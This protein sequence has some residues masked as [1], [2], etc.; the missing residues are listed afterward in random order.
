M[1][2][3]IGILIACIGIVS[4]T[5]WAEPATVDLYA[6]KA[7]VEAV[8]QLA[9]DDI[10]TGL[11]AKAGVDGILERTE[12]DLGHPVTVAELETVQGPTQTSADLTWLQ[13]AAGFVS[14]TNTMIAIGSVIAVAS[15]IFLFGQIIVEMLK[16][17]VM[18]PAIMYESALVLSGVGLTAYA[19]TLGETNAGT[20][21][22]IGALLYGGGFAWIVSRHDN[23][24]TF[25]ASSVGVILAIA[26]GASAVLFQSQLIGTLSVAGLMSAL[27]FSAFMVPGLIV[28]GFKDEDSVPRAMF[29]AFLILGIFVAM[30][31]TGVNAS[32]LSVFRG[33]SLYVGGF[34]A[35]LG[36]LIVGTRYVYRDASYALRQLP[37]IVGGIGAIY[38]GSVLGIPELQKMGG[39]F[40]VLYLMEKPFEIPIESRTGFAFIALLVSSAAIGGFLWANNNLDVVAPY[41]LFV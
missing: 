36:A 40:F 6:V 23:G 30:Q 12:A 3:R 15:L 33:G 14:F 38:L 17:F 7:Q 20:I 29:A 35:Y 21:G 37:M 4:G 8:N 26:W 19:T 22:L 27:G 5:A 16:V 32:F 28:V 9:E 24:R 2:Q 1:L 31:A 18:I 25:S 10:I 41:F 34:V 39:T 11:Q 13:K